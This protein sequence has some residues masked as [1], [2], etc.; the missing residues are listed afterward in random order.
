MEKSKIRMKK[1]LIVLVLCAAFVD[2]QA[3]G[4]ETPFHNFG[5]TASV[6]LDAGAVIDAGFSSS[7]TT[8]HGYAFG[9]GLF[10]GVGT[11]VVFT[12]SDLMSSYGIPFFLECRYSFIDA[13]ASPFLSMRFGGYYNIGGRTG[14]YAAP[15]AGI[16]MGRW[17]LFLKYDYRTGNRT[18]YDSASS[19]YLELSSFQHALS[20]GVSV[21]F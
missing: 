4:R 20:L 6:E 7:L 17:S 15:S 18:I 21:W 5:Y 8:V 16:D 3:K 10:T 1:L 12:P 9:N 19:S 14:L 13:K 11:G 2:L